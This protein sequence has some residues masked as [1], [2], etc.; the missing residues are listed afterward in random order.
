MNTHGI[1]VRYGTAAVSKVHLHVATI[2]QAGAGM[3]ESG[4]HWFVQYI[5]T[6]LFVQ[7]SYTIDST[8][9]FIDSTVL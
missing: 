5:Q 1:T 4:L 8:V 7:S 2:L 3:V 9:L 6:T